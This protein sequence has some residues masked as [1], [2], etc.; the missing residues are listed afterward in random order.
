MAEPAQQQDFLQGK[1]VAFTG[2]LA[3]MT[4]TEAAKLVRAHGGRFIQTV[5]HRLAFLVV[6]QD[7][8]PLQKN[9]RLTNKLRKARA[10]QRAG[11]GVTVLPED[12]L[13]SRLGVAE[14]MRQ[15]Y[16]TA[17]LSDLLR[18]PGETLRRWVKAGLIQPV[19]TVNGLSLFDFQQVAGARTLC[20]LIQAG[21]QPERIRRS[22]RQLQAWVGKVDQPILQL[23]AL[24][25]NGELLVRRDDGL[26][27]PTGQRCFDFAT[28]TEGAATVEWSQPRRSI[29]EWLEL[30]CH[31]EDA[32]RFDEA[33]EIYRQALLAEG[34]HSRICFNLGNALY[35]LG[36]KAQ[37]VERLYQAVELDPDFAEAWNNLGIVLGDAGS[38]QEARLA[39]EK[40]V[41]LRPDY[42]D[43][44]YN[45]AAALDESGEPAEARIHWQAYLAQDQHSEWASRA[46]ARLAGG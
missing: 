35:R 24:E 40:A 42:A 22:I 15:R 10:L 29:D 46:R 6:G 44:R 19:E 39:L 23:A 38:D 27:E 9:G 12:E 3:S 43:A 1:Q 8:W 21:V 14:G 45:L 20:D 2:R 33:A 25:Q 26:M 30:G 32:G 34:P 28:A 41:A 13:L 37:A 4:R 7:G 16:T 18:I 5:T 17:Q 31:Q 36:K 11:H